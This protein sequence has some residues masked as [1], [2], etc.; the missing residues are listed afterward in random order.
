MF[1]MGHNT[2]HSKACGQT[3][4]ANVALSPSGGEATS[5]QPVQWCTQLFGVMLESVQSP[6][7]R[8]FFPCSKGWDK[9]VLHKK[10]IR[11]R[12]KGTHKSFIV[13]QAGVVA[14]VTMVSLPLLMH[15]H[16]CHCCVGVVAVVDMQAS[17]LSLT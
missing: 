8:P 6:S 14:L 1:F 17:L 4:I 10:P 13:C 7:S 2:K 3:K 5:T 12:K 16:L 9:A 11:K 15:R